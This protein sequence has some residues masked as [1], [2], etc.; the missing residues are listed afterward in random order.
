[1]AFTQSDV[2]ALKA[3]IASGVKRVR[4]SDGRETEYASG[5]DLQAAYALAQ[6]EVS[7]N[8][9]TAASRIVRTVAGRDV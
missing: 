9:G 6:A 3:A 5:A 7:Q 4:L 1:M 8:S 2:D